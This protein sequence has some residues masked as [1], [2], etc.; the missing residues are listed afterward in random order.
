MDNAVG[1]ATSGEWKRLFRPT[2]DFLAKG[3]VIKIHTLGSLMIPI[4]GYYNYSVP[5]YAATMFT[6]WDVL[7]YVD[8]VWLLAAPTG[9]HVLRPPLAYGAA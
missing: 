1:C 6:G 3:E 5:R 7:N 4:T 9:H 8:N 2:Q